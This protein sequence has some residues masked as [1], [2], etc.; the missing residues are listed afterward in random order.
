MSIEQPVRSLSTLELE[1]NGFPELRAGNLGVRIAANEA[2]RDAA[3]ALRYRVFYDEMGARP[4]ERTL[5]TRR[6]VDEFD[7]VADHL[8]VIDHAVSSGAKG[9]VGTYRLMQGE[10][11]QKIGRFYSSG[12]YDLSPLTE[13][14]GR[15]LEVGRS[16]VDPNYRGRAAMQLLWRGIASYIFL[17]RIDVLFGCASLPGIDPGPLSDEL[18]YLYHNHLAPPALR[19]R[20][21]PH[22]RVEMLRTDPNTL[23]HR[24]C[25]ARLPPLIK[26]YLRLGGYVGDGAVVDDQFNTTDVAV[27]VKS[28]LLADKY[29]RHYER[30]LRDALD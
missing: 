18:T 26:G 15:L 2:E 6:D 30:R 12:E 4:D 20:A 28:E 24:R 17:H 29:Y 7:N 14:P 11:A 9:V 16:C 23:D 19:L 27:I 10:N 1:R 5:R 13:F 22:R 21:L 25:L 3:Q 8:L